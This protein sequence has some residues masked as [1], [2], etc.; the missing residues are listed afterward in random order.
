MPQVNRLAEA[1]R[2]EPVAVLGM[3]TD[4]KVEDG[5]VVAEAMGLCYPTIRAP[6]VPEKYGVQGYPTLIVIDRRG[7]VREVHVG[8]SPKLFD[9]LSQLVRG[10]LAEPAEG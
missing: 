6:K 2:D 8:Y 3:T 9:E 1:F 7:K 5:R 4:E 10:L